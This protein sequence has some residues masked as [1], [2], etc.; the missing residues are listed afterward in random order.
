MAAEFFFLSRRFWH[1]AE[2]KISA[3][4]SRITRPAEMNEILQY[5]SAVPRCARKLAIDTFLCKN[6][7][8]ILS[9]IHHWQ[10]DQPEIMF[11][12]FIV[13]FL[14]CF[15][16]RKVFRRQYF[17]LVCGPML[18]TAVRGLPCDYINK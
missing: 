14:M 18:R 6:E 10:C 4:A 9:G 15:F 3:G 7:N 11:K 8:N 16:F 2:T 12:N 5:T 1:H 17:D 13:C